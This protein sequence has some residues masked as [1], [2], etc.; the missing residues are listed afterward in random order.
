VPVYASVES[1]KNISFNNSTVGGN[2]SGAME[3]KNAGDVSSAGKTGLS[4]IR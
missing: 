3:F 1:P 4:Q 2:F